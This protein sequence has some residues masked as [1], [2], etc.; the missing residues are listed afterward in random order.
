[1][2]GSPALSSARRNRLPPLMLRM[3]CSANRTACLSWSLPA[4][5]AVAKAAATECFGHSATKS[6]TRTGRQMPMVALAAL[7]AL[8]YRWLRLAQTDR[9]VD[10]S[11]SL[12]GGE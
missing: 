1:M 9:V 5:T 12:G 2:A 7:A 10:E 8:A 6:S 4:A 3:L 11:L